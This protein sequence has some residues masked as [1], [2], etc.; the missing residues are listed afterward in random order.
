MWWGEVVAY[1]K[2]LSNEYRGSLPRDKAEG[3]PNSPFTQY[4]LSH[5]H[6]SVHSWSDTA[7]THRPFYPYCHH[8]CCP[9]GLKIPGFVSL[10]KQDY[11][12]PTPKC[13]VFVSKTWHQMELG[14]ASKVGYGLDELGFESW[15]KQGTFLQ[16]LPDRLCASAPHSPFLNNYLD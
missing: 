3:P 9:K 15:Q 12:T 5:H 8:D 10:P 11:F 6:F 2:V 13:L 14:I 4:G 16:I 7:Y 1:F